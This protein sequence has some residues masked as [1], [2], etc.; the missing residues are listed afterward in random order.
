[1]IK[2]PTGRKNVWG[3]HISDPDPDY[4]TDEY[5]IGKWAL[6]NIDGDRIINNVKRNEL[7]HIHTRDNETLLEIDSDIGV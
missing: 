4:D 2:W 5:V 7:I 3:H 6:D 1:M